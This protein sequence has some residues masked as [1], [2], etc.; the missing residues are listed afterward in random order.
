MATVNLGKIAFTWKGAWS[1]SST[2]SKQ[3]VVSLGGSTYVCTA[4]S[5]T[6]GSPDAT[7]ASWA[8]FAQGVAP[9]AGNGSILY[10]DGES[11][12][13]LPAGDAGQILQI[14]PN[15]GVPS[16]VDEPARSSV[17][18]AELTHRYN[19]PY[20][21]AM[22]L[23][24]DGNL[25]AW[26]YGG[27]YQL[28]QGSNTNNKSYPT[29]VAMPRDFVGVKRSTP[30]SRVR[31]FG[32]DYA[33]L[34]WCVD[35]NNQLWTWGSNAYGHLGSGSTS[36]VHMPTNVSLNS[37]NSIFGK[38]IDQIIPHYAGATSYV[39]TYA[40]C[41]DG[42]LHF[43]GYNG[44]GQAGIGTT[45]NYSY[46][47]H[48]NTLFYPVVQ[49]AV[50]GQYGY[51]LTLDSQ[52]TLRNMGYNGYA[53]YGGS[54]TN[55]SVPMPI[56]LAGGATCVEIMEAAPKGVWVKDSNGDI[57]NWGND[58]SYGFLGRGGAGVQTTAV[59]FTAAQDDIVEIVCAGDDS[60]YYHATS[61]MR[62]ASGKIYA[63]GY[64]GHGQVADTTSS[65]RFSYTECQ[66]FPT[67][68]VKMV[69][70]GNYN[71]YHSM[72]ALTA[73]GKVYVTGYNGNG[74]L[75]V[76]DTTHRYSAVPVPIQQN[77]ID[78]CG[79]GYTSES[80]LQFLLED[81]TMLQSGYGGDNQMPDDDAETSYVPQN[82]IF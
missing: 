80:G 26:G 50:A 39:G 38:E 31:H 25:K 79:T 10:S 40:L 36:A 76:G 4:E 63:A 61:Y 59:V 6:V 62:G 45:T 65:N 73:D 23:M 64:N 72:A 57:Q 17:R 37:N 3:D 69:T 18:V 71:S 78:I 68:V 15:T 11:L 49:A 12:Q 48:V 24:E 53:T 22:V 20:R 30:L 66:G 82:V 32:Q 9:S 56:T 52:G 60:S 28:G 13:E 43:C 46:F 16:W 55:N 81:G 33:Y 58:T 77:V 21:K 51:C 2:Y 1:S 19:N 34:G 75:G 35:K 27:H 67:N 5:A 14:D 29:R 42:T 41:T 7:P 74:Q 47:V 54:T 8:L 70:L 44:H